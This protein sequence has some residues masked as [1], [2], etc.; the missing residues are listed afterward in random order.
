MTSASSE[1]DFELTKTVCAR[2]QKQLAPVPDTLK[3][4]VDAYAHE[5]MTTAA[6]QIQFLM[7]TVSILAGYLEGVQEGL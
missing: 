2:V 4:L 3:K 7:A 5:D 6:A 1:C